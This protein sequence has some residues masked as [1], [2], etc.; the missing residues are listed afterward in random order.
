MTPPPRAFIQSVHQPPLNVYN[1]WSNHRITPSDTP[2][3][4]V[5]CTK[6]VVSSPPCHQ[7][8]FIDGPHHAQYPILH[9]SE[10]LA[11]PE[12]RAGVAIHTAGPAIYILSRHL[13]HYLLSIM[14]SYDMAGNARLGVC[15][16]RFYAVLVGGLYIYMGG[17]HLLSINARNS[18]PPFVPPTRNA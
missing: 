6:A 8:V 18:T 13:L 2:L 5:I 16:M 11:F 9:L 1:V 12:P 10:S 15:L 7:C 17:H 3:H 14:I 4:T